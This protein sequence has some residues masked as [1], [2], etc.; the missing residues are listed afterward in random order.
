MTMGWNNPMIKNAEA[1]SMIPDQSIFCKIPLLIGTKVT[2]IIHNINRNIG[3]WHFTGCL[4]GIRS[5]Y[6][7]Y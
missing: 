1:P 7:P 2:T 6:G 4:Q 3:I 5:Q